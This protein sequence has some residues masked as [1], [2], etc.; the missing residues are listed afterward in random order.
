VNGSSTAQYM[1]PLIA[2][3]LRPFMLRRL[4][5]E[6]ETTLL[7]KKET[8]VFVGMSAMQK[9]LY[10]SIFQKNLDALRGFVK[11]KARL[12][13]TL[14]QLRKAAN[15]PYLFD[16]MEDR[17]LP[18]F[19]DHV[20]TNSGKFVVL[21]KLLAKLKAKGSRV[22]IFS[23]M[24]RALDILEDFLLMREYAYCRLDGS[25]NNTERDEY[26]RVFNAPDSEKFVFLLSTRAGGL[27]INL[28]TADIVILFDSDWNPQMDLQ[29][30]DRAHRI[31]QKKQVYVYRFVTEGSVEE[32]IIE[33]A[34]IK[35]R[36]DAMVIQQGRQAASMSLT[37]Q[38]MMEIIRYGAD[39]VFKQQGSSVTDEDIDLIL[40]RG[41]QKT[42]EMN[43][44]LTKHVGFQNKFSIA[45]ADT[46]VKTEEELKKEELDKQLADMDLVNMAHASLGKRDRKKSNL[47]VDKMQRVMT[48]TKPS[49][50]AID[51]PRKLPANMK[52]WMFYNK[53]RLTELY[54]KET[55]FFEKYRYDL[56]PPD[57]GP[58]TDAEELERETLL[59]EAHPLWKFND[60]KDYTRACGQFGRHNEARIVASLSR[61]DLPDSEVR[62]YHKTFWSKLHTLPG[63]AAILKKIEKGEKDIQ[64]YAKNNQDLAAVIGDCKT[65][66][67]LLSKDA[68]KVPLAQQKGHSP[69][70]D[71][72][73]LL[74]TQKQGYGEWTRVAH[75]LQNARAFHFDYFARS[76]N[77]TDI[78]RRVDTLL[79]TVQKDK[80]KK[81]KKDEAEPE[82]GANERPEAAKKPRQRPGP[83]AKRSQ[84][85][86]D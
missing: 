43:Q 54:E 74:E 25:T 69:E 29:A 31:G 23:Q 18:P 35:L 10:Q 53:A 67:E 27:G 41:E 51:K 86:E 56:N 17:S 65:I 39:M 3:V 38:D 71:C 78:M 2:Q 36:L 63:N 80:Q 24:T 52:D 40:S 19:G 85:G 84:T 11:H 5:S 16:G 47:N 61:P 20:I 66:E 26:M 70:S 57:H 73:I 50:C 79:T 68:L 6:V 32:K 44:K 48:I 72:F 15:H 49:K 9:Q 45:A 59:Q 34:E 28:A 12:L 75:S 1:P 62:R 77:A 22:L 64:K 42:E 55:A 76:R 21:D 37:S 60:H 46:E 81:R 13:N 7:P 58:L 33:R 82:G 30:Q 4:K 14:M 83:K 8:L